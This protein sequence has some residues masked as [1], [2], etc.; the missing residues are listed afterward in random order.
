MSLSVLTNHI[1]FILLNHALLSLFSQAIF[2][3]V[4]IKCS[5]Q[6]S[7]YFRILLKR[8]K[9]P[10]VVSWASAHSWVSAQVLVLA[11]QMESAHS[12]VSAQAR[13]LQSCMASAHAASARQHAKWRLHQGTFHR[14]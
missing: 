4:L 3:I 10:T 8:G 5:T 13:S 2:N 7:V 9:T 6:I 11:A 14:T 1:L 12:R